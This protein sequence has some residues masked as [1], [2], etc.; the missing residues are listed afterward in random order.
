LS[1]YGHLFED[2]GEKTRGKLDAH[3]EAS[4]GGAGDVQPTPGPTVTCDIAYSSSL[5]L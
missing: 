4:A 5:R 1:I 2:T 3:L